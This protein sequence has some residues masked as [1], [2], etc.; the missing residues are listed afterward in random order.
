[1]DDKNA[2]FEIQIAEVSSYN[3][4]KKF[5][6]NYSHANFGGD[7]GT[8]TLNQKVDLKDNAA[9]LT[10]GRPSLPILDIINDLQLIIP[11]K[12][13]DIKPRVH[14]RMENTDRRFSLDLK[15]K[16]DEPEDEKSIV[17][18]FQ[19]SAQTAELNTQAGFQIGA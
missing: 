9:R 18:S 1:M 10:D 13:V 11:G 6:I 17:V 5:D 8:Y 16:R 2:D 12:N 7:Y 14:F 4:P 15:W 19:S 3:I